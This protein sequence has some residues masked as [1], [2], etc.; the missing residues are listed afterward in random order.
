VIHVD[1]ELVG[2]GPRELQKICMP[3]GAPLALDLSWLDRIDRE[4]IRV[5]HALERSGVCLQGMNPYIAMLV[6]GSREP[7]SL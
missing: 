4:G 7:P 6:R 3:L 1:G 5:L 2:E